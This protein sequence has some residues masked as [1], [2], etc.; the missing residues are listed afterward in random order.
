MRSNTYIRTKG[1]ILFLRKFLN[2]IGNILLV[3]YLIFFS[4]FLKIFA[5]PLTNK[6]TSIFYK[7]NEPVKILPEQTIYLQMIYEGNIVKIT[8]TANVNG[9]TTS[10]FSVLDNPTNTYCIVV[11][12]TLLNNRYERIGAVLCRNGMEKNFYMR[13]SEEEIL[14]TINYHI[15][16]INGNN[17]ILKTIDIPIQFPGE[18][19]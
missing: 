14:T 18:K 9:I 2:L 3:S 4:H 15:Y 16:F 7:K 5:Q 1:T 6:S 8:W 17:T 12:A 13:I 10:F 11:D 19:K